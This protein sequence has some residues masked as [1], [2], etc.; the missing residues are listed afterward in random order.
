MAS[1]CT[2]EQ[3]LIETILHTYTKILRLL[4]DIQ[5][6]LQHISS[7]GP[8]QS[9]YPSCYVGE[10]IPHFRME[11]SRPVGYPLTRP[12]MG[13]ST[14]QPT[15]H[16]DP[17]PSMS[18]SSMSSVYAYH[19]TS[20]QPPPITVDPSWS[21]HTPPLNKSQRIDQDPV[22]SRHMNKRPESLDWGGRMSVIPQRQTDP[23]ISSSQPAKTWIR[24][25]LDRHPYRPLNT[26]GKPKPADENP[27]CLSD[28]FTAL[29]D[30]I[31]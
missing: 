23:V 20:L 2:M 11:E 28:I 8:S 4:E 7:P 26:Q 15:F 3:E 30:E 1:S 18:R 25:N 19:S 12:I 27:G 6:R 10:Q 24:S 21:N 17:A 31:R 22:P 14:G 16:P 5:S 29:E 9:Q 13:Y